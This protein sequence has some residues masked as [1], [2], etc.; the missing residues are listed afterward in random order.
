MNILVILLI[1]CI[2]GILFTIPK[3]WCYDNISKS[4]SSDTFK[5][6]YAMI[7]LFKDIAFIFFILKFLLYL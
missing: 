4:E 2:L 5:R 6:L 7:D 3:L 1:S